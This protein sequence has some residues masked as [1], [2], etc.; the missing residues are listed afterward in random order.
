MPIE[1]QCPG[2]GRT[3]RVADEHAGKQAR[4]PVCE[5]IYTVPSSSAL[6]TPPPATPPATREPLPSDEAFPSWKPSAAPTIGDA[7]FL[8]ASNGQVYG[9]V[10]RATLDRWYDEGRVDQKCLVRS[11][12]E[13]RWQPA[14]DIY[15]ALA[16][17]KRAWTTTSAGSSAVPPVG[18]HTGGEVHYRAPHRGVVILVL[19]IL[20]WSCSCPL[21]GIPAWV[22]GS[23][24]LR[25][26][27]AGRMDRSG[28]SLTQIGRILGMVNVI[29]AL[30]GLAFG[31]LSLVLGAVA[32]GL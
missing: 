14:E 11:S 13:A 24:D 21:F 3:L 6:F 16:R 2:C 5:T 31:V 19:G 30:I 27:R 12:P 26:M 10:P 22:M 15:P 29:I 18:S 32:A 9:P 28:E 17:A 20:A 4:C 25:E 23:H 8:K 1:S 7:W